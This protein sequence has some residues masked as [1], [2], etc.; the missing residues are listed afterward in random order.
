MDKFFMITYQDSQNKKHIT[1]INKFSTKELEHNYGKITVQ[2]LSYNK[3][4]SKQG[5]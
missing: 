5:L 3:K 4:S 2:F 1:F